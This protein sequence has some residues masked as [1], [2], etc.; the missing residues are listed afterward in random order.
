[1]CCHWDVAYMRQVVGGSARPVPIIIDTDLSVDVD[2]VGMLCLAHSLADTGEA[3]I[4]A[5]L[6][7]ADAC[8]GVAP[9]GLLGRLQYRLRK[10]GGTC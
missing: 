7:D 3:D 9:G 1:M 8:V 4:L 5:V 10:H 2:D 6:H